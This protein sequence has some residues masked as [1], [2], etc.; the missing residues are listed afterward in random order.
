M[1]SAFTFGGKLTSKGRQIRRPDRR[2]QPVGKCRDAVARVA[3][4][5]D[6]A[7]SK[8][9]AARLAGSSPASGTK[10]VRPHLAANQ[11]QPDFVVFA[12]VRW[13]KGRKTV[14]IKKKVSGRKIA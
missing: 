7:D 4:L 10:T 11:F 14:M 3:E 5:V 12:S 1:K 13:E 9:A 6:A 8:S 2:Y